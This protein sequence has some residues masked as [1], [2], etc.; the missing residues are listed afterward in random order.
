MFAVQNTGMV[1]F[2]DFHTAW[3]FDDKV[4]QKYLFE[5]INA[6]LVPSYVFYDKASALA[7]TE[8]TDF[9]KVFKLRGGAGSAN[10]KLVKTK[11]QARKL[12]RRAFRSGFENFDRWG[13]FRERVRK[14]K[15]SKSG[16][17]DL[18]KGVARFLYPPHYS[19]VMGKERGYVY[20]Q[21]FIPNN[22]YDTRIIV[23]DGKAFG[24]R[25]YVRKNDFRASG[26]GSFAYERELFDERCIKLSFEMTEKIGSQC[27][28]YDF[29]FGKN[30]EP[31]VVEIS[32]GFSPAGYEDCPGYW[33]SDLNW[34]E[35]RFNSQDWMVDLVLKQ[36]AKQ[37]AEA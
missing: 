7:W 35:E 32:Y 21:D 19:K 27:A 12:I 22:A 34:H 17:V 20:F 13:T 26:S 37:K 8:E 14:F 6:P 29:V 9:P 18:A 36:I 1:T 28:A 11:A 16:V 25:R 24:L 31:L 2:P 3:H 33:D 4:G 23:I 5:G 10:V 30:D 15:W